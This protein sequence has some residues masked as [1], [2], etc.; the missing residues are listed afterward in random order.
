MQNITTF[1][2]SILLNNIL[3]SIWTDYCHGGLTFVMDAAARRSTT[4]FTYINGNKDPEIKKY[5]GNSKP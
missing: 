2:D 5:H 4:L 3:K 1:Q